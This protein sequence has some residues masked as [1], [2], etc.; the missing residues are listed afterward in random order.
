MRRTNWTLLKTMLFASSSSGRVTLSPRLGVRL[1]LPCQAWGDL[2]QPRILSRTT[3]T[4]SAPYLGCPE[5][6]RHLLPPSLSLTSIFRSAS[7]QPTITPSL[8][9]TSTPS[10][11]CWRSCT[12]TPASRRR[13]SSPSGTCHQTRTTTSS[14][15]TNHSLPFGTNLPP[16]LAITTS[17]SLPWSWSPT[18]SP[19]SLQR[20]LKN[21]S[22]QSQIVKNL[23]P[24]SVR[25]ILQRL[26]NLKPMRRRTR[27]PRR[28][29]R[30]EVPG[31]AGRHQETEGADGRPGEAAGGPAAQA[32]AGGA[33]QAAAGETGQARSP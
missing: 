20:I 19:T 15:R 2:T 32:G 33:D 22:I 18:R 3:E 29:R 1:G 31:A 13:P 7:L 21:W 25:L 23:K 17:Q 6:P 26:S 10:S 4:P 14:W 24:T 28:R 11:P 30:R 5:V 27:S 8:S 9:R 12:A 16:A